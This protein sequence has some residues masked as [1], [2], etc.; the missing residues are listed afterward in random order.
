MKFD[1]GGPAFPC[2]WEN[3]SENNITAPDGRLMPPNSEVVMQGMTLRD[4]FA[5]SV[6]TE[7][8]RVADSQIAP[9]NA[10]YERLSMLFAMA[11]RYAYYCADAMLEEKKK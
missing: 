8:I 4:Y 3:D 5:A 6:M 7:C 9:G 10:I 11:A 2:V 1:T